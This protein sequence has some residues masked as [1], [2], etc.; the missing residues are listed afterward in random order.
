V[1]RTLT[2]R[3]SFVFV[4]PARR[5][6]ETV[7]WFLRASRQPLPPHEIVAGLASDLEDRWRAASKAARSGRLDEVMSQDA[8]LVA[9]EAE[10][11]ASVLRTLF[12]RVPDGTR[13]LAVGHTPL[14]EAAV[15]GLM[16]LVIEPLGTCEGVLLT[17]DDAGDLRMEELRLP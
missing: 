13:A 2:A 8:G 11:L 5:S 10:R 4:S 12:D 16:N 3:Y 6:A 15:Y 1:G 9:G 17:V 7:A 14:I